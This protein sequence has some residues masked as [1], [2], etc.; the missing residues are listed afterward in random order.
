MMIELAIEYMQLLI[1]GAPPGNRGHKQTLRNGHFRR[2]VTGFSTGSRRHGGG[3]FRK[4]SPPGRKFFKIFTFFFRF[5]P[6][7]GKISKI[8]KIFTIH[9]P[10]PPCPPHVEKFFHIDRGGG[11]LPLRKN[12]NRGVFLVSRRVQQRYL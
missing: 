4:L 5:L 10:A 12:F 9:M 11:S 1:V 2:Q 8:V 3:I 7:Y 6:F